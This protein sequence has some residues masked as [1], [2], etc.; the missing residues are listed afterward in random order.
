MG[1]V[2]RKGVTG[3][4][5]LGGKDRLGDVI[6]RLYEEEYEE[7]DLSDGRTT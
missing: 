5:L 2:G 4:D 7:E 3:S 6:P 1:V